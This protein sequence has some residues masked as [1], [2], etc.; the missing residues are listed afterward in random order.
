MKKI[1]PL[2][3]LIIAG[4]LIFALP[5]HVIRFFRPSLL[6]DYHYSNMELGIAFSVYGIT[7]FLSYLPGGYIADKISPKYLLFSSLLLTSLGGIFYMTNPSIYS[8]YFVFGYWGITTILFFW[9]A[10]I[11]ATRSIAGNNQGI[12]FGALEA[13]RGLVASL[14][15]S[16]AVFLYSNNSLLEFIRNIISKQL[17]PLS[18]VIFFYSCVTFLSSMIILF[19]FKEEVKQTKATKIKYNID[20]IYKNKKPILCISIIVF[21]AY[22]CYKAIDYYSLFFYEILEFSKEKSAYVMAIFSYTRPIAALLA[23]LIADK[24]TSR[25]CTKFLFFFMLVAYASLSIFNL[26]IQLIAIVYVNLIIS[27]VGVFA[28]RGI[29]Y[30]LLKDSYIPSSITGAAVGIISFIGYLPDIFVGPL[31]GFLLDLQDIKVS[32]K[33]FFVFL[34]II[35][36]VGLITA[37]YLKKT[38]NINVLQK[39]YI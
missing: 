29:F 11:K 35:S 37:I 33:I 21:S 7:A 14:C 15:A 25:S 2:T 9:A 28:L 24:I 3:F 27:M 30:S 8:L 1:L 17:S 38:K 18:I 19:F 32:F 23:G 22:T 12:S 13:G 16:I 39:R 20:E 31:F 10:L 36:T 34:F 6:E 26:D 5:F 4:E